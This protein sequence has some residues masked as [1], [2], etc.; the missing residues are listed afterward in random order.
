MIR[1]IVGREKGK[2]RETARQRERVIKRG[3]QGESIIKNMMKIKE[4]GC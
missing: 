1:L 3:R 2:D 4:W